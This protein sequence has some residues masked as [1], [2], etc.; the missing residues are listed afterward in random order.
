MCQAVTSQT[1]LSESYTFGTSATFGEEMVAITQSLNEID[2]KKIDSKE[3][4]ASGKKLG[5]GRAKLFSNKENLP[6]PTV[7]LKFVN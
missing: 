4:L 3:T 1:A 5:K 7:H 2:I 6:R